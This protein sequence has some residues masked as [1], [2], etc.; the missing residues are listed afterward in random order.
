M[1]QS[2]TWGH[3]WGKAPRWPN[4]GAIEATPPL[5]PCRR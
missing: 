5:E 4:R 3:L 2:P 1:G